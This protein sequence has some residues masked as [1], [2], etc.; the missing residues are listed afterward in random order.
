MKP[1]LFFIAK[2]E[3]QQFFFKPATTKNIKTI[4]GLRP[5]TLFVAHLIGNC[6]K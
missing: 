1:I 5:A 6:C 4:A 2:K 3:L